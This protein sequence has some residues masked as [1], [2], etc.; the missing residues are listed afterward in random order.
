[1][2]VFLLEP[3]CAR[4]AGSESCPRFFSKKTLERGSLK[5]VI[6]SPA[7]CHPL[8]ERVCKGSAKGAQFDSPEQRSGK[9]I[10]THPAL[11]G[12]DELAS[13]NFSSPFPKAATGE[14][15][16]SRKALAANPRESPIRQRVV[17]RWFG[18]VRG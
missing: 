6:R 14:P 8:S 15:W 1:M 18:G 3:S 7:T 11:K 9:S 10:R 5:R 4:V 17:A 2:V 16:A 12:R 13:E